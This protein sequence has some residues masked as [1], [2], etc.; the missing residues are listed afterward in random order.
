M[1]TAEMTEGMSSLEV[2]SVLM[3]SGMS[4]KERKRMAA[5]WLEW[6]QRAAPVEDG[7]ATEK[8]AR[9]ESQTRAMFGSKRTVRG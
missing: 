8:T 6:G 7:L 3:A 9:R 2:L 1:I 5:F 4:S